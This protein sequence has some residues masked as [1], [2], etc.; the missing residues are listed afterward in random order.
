ME[1]SG[2]NIFIVTMVDI[3]FHDSI[4]LLA[5]MSLSGPCA[6]MFDFLLDK[7]MLLALQH[8]CILNVNHSNGHK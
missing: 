2:F 1:S 4:M 6:C 8:Y 7:D 3:F 5:C